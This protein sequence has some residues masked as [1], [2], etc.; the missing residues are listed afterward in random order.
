MEFFCSQC[1]EQCEPTVI[2]AGFGGIDY[3]PVVVSTCHE[4]TVV[5]EDGNEVTLADMPNPRGVG[6]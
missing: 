1:R 3:R 4:D 2:D 6:V 5:D